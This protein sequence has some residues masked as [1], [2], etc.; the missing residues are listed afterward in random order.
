MTKA[1]NLSIILYR[2]HEIWETLTS[3]KPLGHSWPVTGLIYFLPI[4]LIPQ[5]E[6]IIGNQMTNDGRKVEKKPHKS[7]FKITQN[8]S[9]AGL[10]ATIRTQSPPVKTP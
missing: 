6:L 2:C 1:D 10:W 9:I 4:L 3:W 8:D 7:Y 5:V